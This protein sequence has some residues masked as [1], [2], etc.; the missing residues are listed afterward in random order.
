M[1]ANVL[2]S[3]LK[4][5]AAS[6]PI[7][8]A[9]IGDVSRSDDHVAFFEQGKHAGEMGGA[10]TEIGVHCSDNREP[11]LQSP[12][13]SWHAGSVSAAQAAFSPPA[14]IPQ[15]GVVAINFSTMSAVP[16]GESSSTTRR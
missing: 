12:W 6:R 5:Y 1:A 16:S 14:E 3:Q 7:H 11:I 13:P 2:A 4:R 10:V 9:S 15:V 8:G